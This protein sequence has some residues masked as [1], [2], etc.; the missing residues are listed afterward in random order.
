MAAGL[1]QT[2]HGLEIFGPILAADRFDHF[3][4][5]NGVERFVAACFSNV[6]VVLQAQI[7]LRA[8]TGTRHTRLRPRQLLGTQRH[9]DERRVEFGRRHFGQ[10]APAATNLQHPVTGLDACH[11]QCAPHLGVLR[12]FHRR[13]RRLE[14][15]R[16]II[17]R[18]VQPQRIK[19]I[20]QVVVGVDIFL[21]VGPGVAVEPVFDAVNETPQPAAVNHV[22]DFIAVGNQHLQQGT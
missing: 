18:A 8:C 14:N 10:R 7:S 2:R 5:A 22:L 6:A 11:V 13:L 17:H 15:S 16:R 3:D 19:S 21:A 12:V 4:R 1:E 20:A 9:A